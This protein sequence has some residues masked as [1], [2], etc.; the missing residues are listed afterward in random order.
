MVPM[1]TAD[2]VTVDQI[3]TC[4][5]EACVSAIGSMSADDCEHH[6]RAILDRIGGPTFEQYV[7]RIMETM[8]PEDRNS[9]PNDCDDYYFAVRELFPHISTE[10]D[11]LGRLAA[12]VMKMIVLR[13]EGKSLR[14]IAK[15]TIP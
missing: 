11:V 14:T 13:V 7:M 15:D 4:D 10:D 8:I 5:V 12:L 3:L 9:P 2:R 6:A 1:G